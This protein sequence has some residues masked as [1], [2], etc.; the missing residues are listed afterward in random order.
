MSKLRI[1]MVGAG[2]IGREHIARLQASPTC[3]VS[4]V[5]DPMPEARRIAAA[6]DVP[7]FGTMAELFAAD[8]PDGVIIGT[9]NRFHVDNALECL[10]A[11]VPA[12]I[13]KPAAHTLAEGERL[14]RAVEASQV[15]CLVGHHRTHSPIMALARKVVADGLLGRL[16]AVTGS[17]MFCKPDVYFQE[18]PW[19]GEPGGGPVLINMIHEIGNLRSLCGEISHVQAMAS[20]VARHLPVEDTVALSLQFESGVLGTFMLSDTVGDAR[21][22]EQT[23]QENKAYATYPDE[24]CYVLSGTMGSLAVPTMRLKTFARQQDRSWYTAMQTQVL[25]L[26]RK[27]PLA[28]QIEHFAAVIRGEAQPLVTVRDGVQNVR[29]VEAIIEAARTGLRTSVGNS[30]LSA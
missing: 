2:A 5:V 22:W 7:Y 15:P 8:R 1:A 19:R 3:E 17:A 10:A 12:L 29:V 21:S 6:V 14:C 26:A 28:E 30:A 13:E 27:D 20:S 16:V 23:S 24:D 25:A 11:G 9:P 18:A 4:A